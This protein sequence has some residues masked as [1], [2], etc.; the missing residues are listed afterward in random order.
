M[1][2]EKMT[3]L[4]NSEQIGFLQATTR[5]KDDFRKLIEHEFILEERT[6][7]GELIGLTGIVKRHGLFRAVFL[8][9]KKEHQGKGLGSKLFERLWVSQAQKPWVTVY[10]DNPR[11][12]KIY[13]K[14][15]FFLPYL[16][17]KFLGIPKA[18]PWKKAGGKK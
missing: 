3:F 12:L 9:I 13:E 7:Q 5:N 6:P 4:L 1:D 10:K 14:Y 18:G 16:H 15:Y 8:A 17:G 11:A 2:W